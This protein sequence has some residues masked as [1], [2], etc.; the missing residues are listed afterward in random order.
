[1]TQ[2][3][4]IDDS[5][6]RQG[7][8]RLGAGKFFRLERN[9]KWFDANACPFPPSNQPVSVTGDHSPVQTLFSIVD[10]NQTER[11]SF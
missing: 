1:M 8:R 4:N 6:F 2:G 3:I 11:F 5:K 7:R 10:T 9:I